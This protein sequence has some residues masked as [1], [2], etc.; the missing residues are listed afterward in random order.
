[1]LYINEQST[2]SEKKS[3]ILWLCYTHNEG[4]GKFHTLTVMCHMVWDWTVGIE[5]ITFSKED[6]PQEII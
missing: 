4:E 5:D 3:Y 2:D 6:K 1:M